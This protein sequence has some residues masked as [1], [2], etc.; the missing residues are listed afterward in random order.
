MFK[1]FL[2]RTLILILLVTQFDVLVKGESTRMGKAFIE[3]KIDKKA[4]KCI[5]PFIYGNFMEFLDDHISGMWAEKLK[6]RRFED[7]FK[8]AETANFWYQSGYNNP[9]E[10][11]VDLKNAFSG[12]ACQKIK[13]LLDKKGARGISQDGISV[14]KDKEY[15]CNVY[16]KQQNLSGSVDISIG[17]DYGPIFIPYDSYT[18]SL[19]PGSWKEYTFTLVPRVSDMNATFTIRFKG[20]GTL[21]I[22]EV[23]LIAKDN[24]KGWRRD[25]SEL[26]KALRPNIIRFPGG[27]Y[28]D[29]YHWKDGIGPRDKRPAT[30]NLPWSKMPE[31]YRLTDRPEVTH[32]RLIET[33]DVGIDEFMDLCKYAGS[34]ALI[35][36]NF[37]SGTPEEAAEWVEYCNGDVNTKYGAMRTKNGHPEPYRIK[38]WEVGNEIYGSW[39]IGGTNVENYAER[40]MDFYKAMKAVDPSIK[41]IAVGWDKKWN[42]RLLEITGEY[43]DYLDIHLYP[44]A[45]IDLFSNSNEDIYRSILSQVYSCEKFI[46]GVIEDIKGAGLQDKLKIAVCEWNYTGGD[47]GSNR[48]RLGTLGDAL[49]SASMLN[50]FQRYSDWVKIANFSNLTNAWWASCIRTNNSESHVTP[51]YRVLQLYSNYCGDIPLIVDIDCEKYKI[52]NLEVPYLDAMATMDSSGK[53]VIIT[54]VNR[55]DKLTVPAEIRLKDLSINPSKAKVIIL[56]GPSMESLNDF[57]FPNL[58]ELKTLEIMVAENFE[59]AFPASSLTL[60]EVP[61]R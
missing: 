34:E 39:E 33:N 16:L 31:D 54:I 51:C 36:V 28:A 43:I 27:C 58:I 44:G 20:E 52:N 21:W 1:K 42:E 14:E 60:I 37:G 9:A 24:I 6:N 41:V 22:D 13:V 59:Y 45:G 8:D 19:V 40:Y 2:T 18:I 5:S 25:V 30:P 26:V 11:I 38:Y 48:V 50:M 61:L 32:S 23:S 46:Q 56:S 49:F 12:K 17:K 3:V 29:G 57:E 53:R 4:K 35:C 7:L 15:I 10:Y 55:S 47:W